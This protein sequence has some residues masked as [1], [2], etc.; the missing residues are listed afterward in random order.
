MSTRVREL[1][2]NSS[3]SPSQTAWTASLR[4]AFVTINAPGKCCAAIRRVTAKSSMEI[5]HWEGLVGGT[6]VATRTYSLLNHGELIWIRPRRSGRIVNNG[7]R[8]T[9]WE[10]RAASGPSG[11]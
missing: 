6:R 10:R 3:T 1:S 8:S 11:A 9:L 4:L 5:V 7:Q 2:I